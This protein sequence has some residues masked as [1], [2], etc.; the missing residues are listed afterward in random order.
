MSKKILFICQGNVSRSQM[1]EALYN[2]ATAS[3]KGSSAGLKSNNWTFAN[4][5]PTVKV[6]KEEGIDLS[7]N[8]VKVLTK[9]MIKIVDCIII[10]EKEGQNSPY[11]IFLKEAIVSGKATI[12]AVPDTNSTSVDFVRS[13]KNRI[14]IIINELTKG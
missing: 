1:A 2:E 11:P 8:L 6:M 9:P 3:K 13:I 7:Q 10:L 12:N 4:H 5:P 14:K